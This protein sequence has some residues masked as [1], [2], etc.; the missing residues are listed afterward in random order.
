MRQPFALL[1]SLALNLPSWRAIVDRL[2]RRPVDFL[3]REESG[4]PNLDHPARVDR[5]REGGRRRSIGGFPDHVR[6]SLA[7]GKVERFDLRAYALCRV[8]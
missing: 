8:D 6:I 5:E 1:A 3:G 7:E 4:G 2:L